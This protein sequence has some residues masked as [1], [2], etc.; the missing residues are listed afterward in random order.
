MR[1]GM[2][3]PSIADGTDSSTCDRAIHPRRGT[4]PGR[5]L[6]G[7]RRSGIVVGCRESDQLRQQ[8]RDLLVLAQALEQP[9]RR[10]PGLPGAL[11]LAGPAASEAEQVQVTGLAV[12]IP[13]GAVDGA[14]KLEQVSAQADL[15][16]VQ[17]GAA[18]MLQD[19]PLEPAGADLAGERQGLPGGGDGVA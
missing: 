1:P 11:P 16:L 14:G 19:V 3:S 5:I 6:P 2:G 9:Q 13:V 4:L 8:P 7:T 18:E 15:P 17:P 10:L 12:L